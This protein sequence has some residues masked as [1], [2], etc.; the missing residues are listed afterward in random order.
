MKISI[1]A[2]SE[3]DYILQNKLS[4]VQYAICGN[5]YFYAIAYLKFMT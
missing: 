1:D 4:D 5:F 3:A 2:I